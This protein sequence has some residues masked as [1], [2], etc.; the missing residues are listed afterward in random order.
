MQGFAAQGL[1]GFAAQGLQ[2][3]AAQGLHGLQ[4]LQGLHG[5][6]AAQGLHGF[7]A[8]GLQGFAA[9]GLHGLQGLQGLHGFDAAQGLQGFAAASRGMTHSVAPADPPAAQ[10]LQGF[11]AHGLQG[12]AAQGLQGLGAQGLQGLQAIVRTPSGSASR[13]IASGRTVEAAGAAF[14]GRTLQ[15]LRPTPVAAT[16]S[17]ITADNTVVDR[18]CRFKSRQDVLS[19]VVVIIRPPYL[20]AFLILQSA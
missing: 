2:G 11:A 16:P 1:H 17:P 15:R 20:S 19:L 3:F 13:L 8:Q 7:A 18:S 4:G 5:F 14:A 10:G 9:Q 6:D 12:F